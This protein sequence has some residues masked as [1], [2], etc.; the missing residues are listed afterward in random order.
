M[1]LGNEIADKP[2]APYLETAGPV[3]ARARELFPDAKVSVIGCFGQNWKTCAPTLKKVWIRLAKY[4]AECAR[5]MILRSCLMLSLSTIIVQPTLPSRKSARRT[6]TKGHYNSTSPLNSG[7]GLR[8]WPPCAGCYTGTWT[9][10]ATTFL[11]MYPSGLM[12]STGAVTG[13]ARLHGHGRSTV[14]FEVC[15]GCHECWPALRSTHYPRQRC[16]FHHDA[17]TCD[18]AHRAVGKLMP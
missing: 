2:L 10:S 13:V 9:A 5:N 3:V 14:H 18:T 15:C 8:R 6:W 1:E 4:W 16:L 7:L 11:Q 12:S 17:V